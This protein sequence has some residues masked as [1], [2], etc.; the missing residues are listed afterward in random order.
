MDLSNYLDNAIQN[1]EQYNIEEPINMSKEVF[2]NT[3]NIYSIWKGFDPG[4]NITTKDEFM[5][6]LDSNNSDYRINHENLL[7]ETNEY[8]LIERICETV[9]EG[10][11]G[12]RSYSSVLSFIKILLNNNKKLEL[13]ND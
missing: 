4:L 3:E 11:T 12:K 7:F 13:K 5:N 6:V 10:Y 2:N 9:I 8:D 1:Y